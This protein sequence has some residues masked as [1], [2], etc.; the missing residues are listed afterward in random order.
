[1]PLPV[2]DKS[3][4]TTPVSSALLAGLID[5]RDRRYYRGHRHHYRPHRYYP[6]RYYRPR[7]RPLYRPFYRP[8]YGW[9]GGWGGGLSFGGIGFGF[10]GPLYPAPRYYAPPPPPPVYRGGLRPWSPEWY[11]YC[12]A[13]Y[14]SFN[15][16]TGTYTAYSGKTRF[17][18]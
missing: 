13:K 11:R 9:G 12:S 5:V 10:G 3:H 14:R 7:Y 1:M 17:C 2:P 15:P 6:R 16:R 18:R 8:Y 4:F